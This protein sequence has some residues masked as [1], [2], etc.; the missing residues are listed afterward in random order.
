MTP[1]PAGS[2]PERVGSLVAW[3]LYDWANSAYFTLIQTFVFA[4]YFTRQIA[5]DPTQGTALWGNAI[6]AAGL[7]VA[8]SGPVLG[9]LA[10]HGGPRRL[11]LTNL[12]LIAVLATAL[13]W[14]VQP[15]PS[16]LVLALAL[17]II[18][19]V[20]AELAIVLYN[21]MLP[22]LAERE[23]IGRWSGWGWG[24]GYVGGLA[25]LAVA[26]FGFVRPDA[27]FQLPRE[28][29]EHVRAT[30]LLTAGWFFVFALPLLVVVSDSPGDRRPVRAAIRAG[31]GQLAT[32]LRNIRHYGDIARFLLARMLYVDGL[33]TLF[34]FGGVYAAGTFAM[35]EQDILLFGI[36]LN[37]TA[38]AGAALFAWLDDWLGPRA[39][40]LLALG[41]L[42]AFAIL[43]LLVE[44]QAAFWVLGSAIG[45][46]VGPAQA[47]ARSYLARVAPPAQRAELFG[48]FALSG[49]ATAFL[50]PLLVGWLT[51]L[52]DSQRIG[53]SVIVAF[54]VAGFVLMLTVP[55][56][57]RAPK[58]RPAS[59]GK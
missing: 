16:Y 36:L 48:L 59:A 2:Q 24:L 6:A 18:G 50:G 43:I 21:A 9:A 56:A 17:M 35:T 40:I 46:F 54:F 15:D 51:L 26:L 4:A 12:T 53:M 31:L 19:T 41:G 34:A 25:C 27:W 39:T 32:T 8:V 3:A 13:M 7:L 1:K 28:N 29:A 55:E 38:A 45:I 57:D 10:D 33:A 14:L 20:T 42:I 30:F 23:R 47:A 22:D 52:A 44:T 5:A 11:L 49:K 58:G 37:V